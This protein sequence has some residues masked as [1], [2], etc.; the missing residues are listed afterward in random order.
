[1]ITIHGVYRSRA[2]RNFWLLEETG[3]PFRQVPVIQA[4]RLADPYAADAPLNTQSAEFIRLNPNAT[5]PVMQDGDLVL[6]ESLA[7]NLYLARQYGGATGPQ[8][9]AEDALF[10]MWS[11]WAATE[12]EPH[13]IQIL[14]NRVAKPV[15]Q[16]DA[17]L[18][19]AAVAALRRPVAVLEQTL[20]RDGY[21]VGGRFTVAD[22]N[23]SEV[24]R[25]ALAAPELF[26]DAP[27]VRAWI[28]RLH[29]RPGF[30]KMIET[31]EREP[32]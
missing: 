15:E 25:Y 6:C 18:A 22:I 31:R 2:S 12:V 13:S 11:L 28:T 16:R 9:P 10:S 30:R 17:R 4:Y 27:A 29:A 5:V 32:A 19:E 14:Y 1:M 21:L 8:T 20:A 23:V 24:V 3:T 26:E 7:I